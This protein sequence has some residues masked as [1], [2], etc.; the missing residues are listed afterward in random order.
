MTNI[1]RIPDEDSLFRTISHKLYLQENL[2]ETEIPKAAIRLGNDEKGMSVDWSKYSTAEESQERKSETHGVISWVVKL[3]RE[4]EAGVLTVE[5][6]P[7]GENR[8]H[9]LIIPSLR[10]K[11]TWKRI[12]TYLMRMAKIEITPSL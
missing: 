4:I 3:V 12:R 5:H 2:T 11:R 6:Q 8:A 7:N 10:D 9:S 1:E